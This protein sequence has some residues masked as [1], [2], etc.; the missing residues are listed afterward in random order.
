MR[1]CAS[2]PLSQYPPDQNFEDSKFILNGLVTLCDQPMI[3]I[4]PCKIPILGVLG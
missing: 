2:F 4:S 3:E 1:R